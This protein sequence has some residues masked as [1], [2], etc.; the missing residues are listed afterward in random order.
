MRLRYTKTLLGRLLMEDK[1]KSKTK[2]S[3]PISQM[4]TVHILNAIKKVSKLQN[5]DPVMKAKLEDELKRR[6]GK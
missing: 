2:G 4:H 1:Y 3:I 6:E 5:Y